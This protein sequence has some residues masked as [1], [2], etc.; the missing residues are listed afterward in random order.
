[1]HF[2]AIWIEI[3][4]SVNNLITQ[5]YGLCLYT[6][7]DLNHLSWQPLVGEQ[8]GC[9]RSTPVY[10]KAQK[11]TGEFV[12]NWHMPRH[13]TYLKVSEGDDKDEIPAAPPSL[14]LRLTWSVCRIAD[15][16]QIA[17]QTRTVIPDQLTMAA[18]ITCCQVA[19]HFIRY[20]LIIMSPRTKLGGVTM[21]SWWGIR[22]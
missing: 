8:L 2:R 20:F 4:I 13:V 11:D 18:H 12:I 19:W 21:L 17:C 10:I 5:I 3:V 16:G 15:H 6:G 14:P 7:P 22:F 9:L 1:M